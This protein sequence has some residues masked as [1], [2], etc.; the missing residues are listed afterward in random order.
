MLPLFCQYLVVRIFERIQSISSE[1]CSGCAHGYRFGSLHPCVKTSLSERIVMFLPQAKEEAIEK[2]S[3]LVSL[4]EQ[5][6]NLSNT[7]TYSSVGKSFLESLEQK[8]VLDRR[9]INEDAETMFKYD[10]S[11]LTFQ[12]DPF[13]R[14]CDEVFGDIVDINESDNQQ[15][16]IQ[17]PVQTPKIAKRKAMSN[18][19]NVDEIERLSDK[20]KRPAMKKRKKN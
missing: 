15:S 4:F 17:T 9:F 16:P 11:W 6:F 1:K 18:V 20:P 12:D 19:H 2:M 8:Q 5:D 3:R 7:E 14:L 10:Q 13:T